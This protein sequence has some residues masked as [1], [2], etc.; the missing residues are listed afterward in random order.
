VLVDNPGRTAF[1]IAAIDKIFAN[2]SYETKSASEAVFVESM[3]FDLK[4]LVLALKGF[5]AVAIGAMSLV[6]LNTMAMAVRERRSE[7]AVMRALGF[8][9][10]ILAA[11]VVA[12]SIAIGLLG[13]VA[14]AALAYALARLLPFSMLA[15]G[16]IDLFEILP[17]QLLARALGVSV[18]IGLSAGVLCLPG[19]LR[20]PVTQALREV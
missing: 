7:F 10:E 5:A 18:V 6:A 9:P 20:R 2:S 13:W 19:M 16:P 15:L 3:L 1:T 17:L 14:G 4:S 11:L 12:E 8:G